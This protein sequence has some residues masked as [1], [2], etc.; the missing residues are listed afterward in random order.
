MTSAHNTAALPSGTMLDGRY[1]IERVIGRGGFG[2]TYEAVNTVTRQHVA[3]KEWKAGDQA[4]FLREARTLRDFAA[5]DAVV[6]VLDYLQEDD[7]AFLVM[8]Y[9]DGI[10]L[11]EYIERSGKLPTET[12]INLFRPIFAA[13][14]QI[15]SAGVIHR[16]ISPDNLMVLGEGPDICLKLMDFGAARNYEG[17][18]VTHSVIYKPNYSPPEQMDPGG[19]M[20]SFTDVYALCGTIC[21][22]ITGKAPEDVIS[23]LLLDELE[24]PSAL[25]A[26]ILP[27]AEKI[28][29][30]GLALD[31]EERIRDI[32]SLTNQLYKIY[33][34]LSE[35]EKKAEMLRRRQRKQ[36]IAAGVA[37]ALLIAFALAFWQRIRLRFLL[38]DTITISLDGND[39]E[40]GEFTKAAAIVKERVKV[41]SDGWYLW[42]EAPAE[43][44]ILFTVPAKLFDPSDP[45]EYTRLALSRPM[46]LTIHTVDE[47][48][49]ELTSLGVFDKRNDLSE[50]RRADGFLYIEFTDDAA[51]RFD[52]LLEEK[53]KD[54]Y[55]SF[56]QETEEKRGRFY[57][58]LSYKFKTAGDGRY[59]YT[60][61]HEKDPSEERY[62]SPELGI[63]HLTQDTFD[64]HFSV[65]ASHCV[66]WEDPGTAL[67]PGRLQTNKEK[68][69]GDTIRLYYP[70][71]PAY[72]EDSASG[73]ELYNSA[74][75][76]LQ[77]IIKNRLD[78]RG[79]PY[80]AGIDKYDSNRL[81]FELP[82]DNLWYIEAE[83]LADNMSSRRYLGNQW[84]RSS[85]LSLSTASYHIE[86]HPDGSFYFIIEPGTYDLENTVKLAETVQAQGSD[87]FLYFGESPIASCKAPEAI[88]SLRSDGVIRFTEW[89]F[90][91]A[92]EMNSQTR[93]FAAFLDIGIKQSPQKE[94]SSSNVAVEFPK[95]KVFGY[96]NSPHIRACLPNNYP[97]N[98]HVLPQRWSDRYGNKEFEISYSE[99]AP[100]EYILSF[101]N[102]DVQ[103][104]ECAL[105]VLR[106][107]QEKD[108]S[109]LRDHKIHNLRLSFYAPAS[110]GMYAESVYV[111][112]EL[113]FQSLA[114]QRSRIYAYD[115]DIVEDDE[116]ALLWSKALPET[117][118]PLED[119]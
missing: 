64:G 89:A 118:V 36:R 50:V 44:R 72:D 94:V 100:Y 71:P 9:L 85:A 10:T 29:M 7:A 84:L 62:V 82:L 47:K 48:S 96:L 104:P 59:I 45:Q 6:T 60:Q 38:E 70:M 97:K 2:I 103:D 95:E 112:Y 61:L 1:R 3:I 11:R 65:Y 23:R 14:E 66:R 12:V 80:A 27:A 108:S 99:Y 55:I 54:V 15:H 30:R 67:M 43:N 92:G 24:P 13:L 46:A 41:F 8:E 26:D 79:I 107:I 33:P 76:S 83:L 117:L 114:L 77:V 17:A 87:L 98:Q 69:P 88:A 37:A 111:Y 21:Y 19:V 116:L 20:G 16:D 34:D 35:E 93:H 31:S 25:G 78:A 51:A 4:G 42:E 22:C 75:I 40:E 39:F 109:F 63:L 52:G 106:D 101:Y 119:H 102:C 53:D 86:D 28:L 105:E 5:I 49:G 74:L 91:W 32:P 110:S 90:P 73:A 81:I 115:N 68:L 58:F 18:N 56:D 113:D 57:P